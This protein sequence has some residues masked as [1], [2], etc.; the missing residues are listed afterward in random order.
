MEK[1]HLTNTRLVYHGHSVQIN[2]FNCL[3]LF[4]CHVCFRAV[5]VFLQVV[6]IA[7]LGT[8]EANDFKIPLQ[9]YGFVI[10]LHSWKPT[11]NIV[12]VTKSTIWP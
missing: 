9:P 3:V 4:L 2:F 10:H 12:Y 5:G 8:T 7:N 6:F 1:L 11:E